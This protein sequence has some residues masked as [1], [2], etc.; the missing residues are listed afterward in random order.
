MLD[1]SWLSRYLHEVKSQL[2]LI[3]QFLC[4]LALDLC[5]LNWSAIC[6]PVHLLLLSKDLLQ[7]EE[8][9]PT[10]IRTMELILWAQLER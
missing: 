5:T 4:V 10:Y 7:E 6:L 3:F 1:Q 9:R 8:S 2:K